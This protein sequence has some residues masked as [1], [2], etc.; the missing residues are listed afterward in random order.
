[1]PKIQVDHPV[2]H[3]KNDQGST[4]EPWLNDWDTNGLWEYQ[5]QP[6][7][8]GDL[9]AALGPLTADLPVAVE[10]CDPSGHV[11][12]LRPMHIDAT[13]GQGQATGII[14]TAA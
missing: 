4:H 14:I 5:V 9:L 13:S 8:V 7:T 1:V 12:A 6:L 2:E 10:Y 3:A 11:T